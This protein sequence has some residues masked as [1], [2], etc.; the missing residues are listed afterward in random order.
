MQSG[1]DRI[2]L[3]S[4]ASVVKAIFAMSVPVMVGM[5]VQVFYNMVDTFFIGMMDDVNQLAAA[6]I[7]FPFFMLTMA[8]GSVVGVGSSSLVSRFLGMK[9]V[10][11]A[12][13][14][15]SLS[16]LLNVAM[17]IVITPIILVFMDPILGLLGAKGDV[18]TPTRQYIGP[19]V[20]S[21]VIIMANFSM[22]VIVRAEGA[23]IHAMKG[24]LIGTVTNIVLDPI[25]IFPMG[26]GIGGAAW[27]TVI[28]NL[29]GLLYYLSGYFGKSM[30]K[31]SFG[32]HILKREYLKG[33]LS[34]GIPSGVN[35]A[36]MSFAGI[37]ANNLASAYG[38]AILAAMGISQRINSL[39][40]LLL[41]GLATGCQPLFGYNYGAGNRRRLYKILK[42]SMAISVGMGLILSVIFVIFGRFAVSVFT[43]I[44]E[45]IGYSTLMLRAMSIAAP[46]IGI[47][48]ICMN[49]LQAFGKALPS[50]IL[51]MGRQGL[52][53]IPILFLLTRLFGLNGLIFTQAIVDV[54][55][56]AI[57]AILLRYVLSTDK[58]L[59]GNAA[60]GQS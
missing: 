53:Y 10:R 54:L 32:R 23:A 29:A 12:G 26:M 17:A 4:E 15:V 46:F 30:L 20:I 8:L 3:M 58:L 27:A 25:M 49:S 21:S 56:C 1:K 45:V 41:V 40:I 48:M 44:P 22:G 13:E 52:F 2:Y 6:S 14:I 33:V 50:L 47:Y 42:T 24:M 9:K 59:H 35:H 16:M 38:P 28:G 51:S 55:I 57:A 39:I 7:G 11:E 34:I 18:L 60:G 31:I 37:V 36:L 19:L 5:I 43:E